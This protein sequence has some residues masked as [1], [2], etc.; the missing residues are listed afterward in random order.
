VSDRLLNIIVQ[1]DDA[2]HP[3]RFPSR[4][5][6]LFYAC[7]E[8]IRAGMDDDTI[9]SIILDRDL[10]IAASVIDKP[11][12]T[13][14]AARQIQRARE[15]VVSPELRELNDQYAVIQNY[16]GRCRVIS[17]D[18]DY[19]VGGR[20]RIAAHSFEDFRNMH[21]NRHVQVGKKQE[22][23]G[24]WWLHH[25]K[26]REYR[27]IIFA[28]GK[29]TPDD[30][31]NLWQ[32]FACE[33]VPGDCD[34]FL[35][36]VRTNI[37]NGD[38]ESYEYLLNWMA[39]AVQR[40]DAPGE[41]AVV[42]RGK[43]GTGKSK[44]AKVFGSLWGQHFVTVSDPKHL[45]G[46]FNAHLK[47]CVVLLADEAFYAGDKKHESI[48]KQVVT[49]QTIMIEG[50]GVDTVQ[51][52]NY[53]H[54]IMASN[55]DWVVPAGNEERHFFVLDVGK[56]RMQDFEFFGALDRQMDDGGRKALLHLLQT[57]D[58]TSFNVRRYPQTKALREQKL[59]SLETHEEEWVEI[60]REGVTP[61]ADFWKPEPDYISVHGFLEKLERRR[62][63]PTNRRGLQ[64][65]VGFFLKQ[66]AA[67]DANGQIIEIKVRLDC[68]LING[69]HV[70]HCEPTNKDGERQ[71]E[72]P[73]IDS[74]RRTMIKLRPLA[75]PRKES[76]MLVG[77][78][79][80]SPSR[81]I[82]ERDAEP[83]VE[84]YDTSDIPF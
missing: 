83:G 34:L 33:A 38:P 71:F 59:L 28:P 1:G 13:E 62:A 67:Q 19:A 8:L 78:W 39:R 15:Q 44:F 17:E 6:V 35:E 79:P 74:V 3:N 51:S 48:L 53:I 55:S 50:K 58:L 42:L 7:C 82:L 52:P 80:A 66:Y 77:C 75:E 31:Y 20:T 46:S 81:W 41:V 61:D 16:G 84:H 37:C 4:S 27:T 10:G 70:E 45:T 40:P 64:T 26:R 54:L 2:E 32:G 9:A 65:K 68:I 43:Q 22:E 60:L 5:E 21:C 24:K 69:R 57:R 76:E 36:H 23:L 29:T 18:R 73:A 25:P 11:R 47:D 14:Y 63:L 49:D 56:S 30:V 12:P 72:N